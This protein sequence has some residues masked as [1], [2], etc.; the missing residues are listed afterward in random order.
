MSTFLHWKHHHWITSLTIVTKTG[1]YFTN[2]ISNLFMGNTFDN[3]NTNW[4]EPLPYTTTTSL[5]VKKTVLQLS[6]LRKRERFTSTN[7]Q[8]K[9]VIFILIKWQYSYFKL[10]EKYNTTRQ[11]CSETQY[12]GTTAPNGTMSNSVWSVQIF[13]ND[14]CAYYYFYYHQYSHH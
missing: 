14:Q 5:T 12:I 4:Y 7:N 10:L 1:N 9:M 6:L 13:I 8:N 11:T 2:T 3:G